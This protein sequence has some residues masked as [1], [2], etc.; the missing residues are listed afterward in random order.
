MPPW[1]LVCAMASLAFRKNGGDGTMPNLFTA[2]R[3][4]ARP[5]WGP[6]DAAT[7]LPAMVH[8]HDLPGWLLADG[9]AAITTIIAAEACALRTRLR[10]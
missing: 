8:G 1:A 5:L 10:R 4:G 2:A 6:C 7:R 9:M 3:P